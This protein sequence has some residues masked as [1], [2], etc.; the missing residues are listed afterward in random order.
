MTE[1]VEEAEFRASSE[2]G[3]GAGIASSPWVV[4]KFGGSSVA[5]AANWKN[6]VGVVRNRL[7]ASLRPMVVHSAIAG[8]SNALE[9]ILNAAVR[10]DADAEIAALRTRHCDLASS[11][12]LDGESL[13]APYFAEMQ[14]IAAGVQLIHEVSPRVHVRMLAL[15]VL[16]STTLGAAYLNANGIDTVWADARKLLISEDAPR[17]SIAQNYLSALCNFDADPAL[18]ASLQENGSVVLTQGFIAGNSRGEPVLLGREGSDT[19]AAYF[20]A[21][22][23]ARRLEIWTDVPGMF[24]ADPKLVPSARLLAE[25]HFDEAQELSSTGSRVLHPRCLGPLRRF[26]IPL[27]IR[28]TGAPRTSPWCRWRALPCGTRLAFSPKRLPASASTA[29]RLT[30][31]QRRKPTSRCRSRTTITCFLTTSSAHWLRTLS[32]CAGCG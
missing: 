28:C 1:Q 17:R 18:S 26:G 27:F 6:I 22:L 29:Y 13:L 16:M 23:Q 10:G 21:R 3:A 8:A 30:L 25:L 7:A 20:A 12:G 14:Q 15:G 2:L 4:L 9:S 31:Y 5:T 19:S 32:S 24:T 11:L